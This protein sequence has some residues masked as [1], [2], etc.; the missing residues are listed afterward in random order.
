MGKVTAS[1]ISFL[2]LAAA[3][4]AQTTGTVTVGGRAVNDRGA[5][6]RAAEYLPTTSGTELALA[7]EAAL[8]TVYLAVDSD[9]REGSDQ[10]HHL[11]VELNRLVRSHTSFTKMPHRLV[12]DPLENL[13]GAVKMPVVT[14]S[15]DLDPTARYRVDYDLLENRTD[16]QLPQAGWLTVSAIYREQWRQG[17]R[18]SL[19]ISH[20]STCHVQS[21][22]RAVDE[23]TRDAGVVAQ[24]RAGSWKLEGSFVARDFEEKAPTPTRVYE[25]AEQ[26]ALRQPLFNDRVWYDSKNGPL[27]YGVIPPSEKNTATARLSNPNVGGFAVTLSGVSTRL[28]NLTTGNKVDFD[29]IALAVGRRLGKKG[30]FALRARSYTIDSTDYFVDVPEPKAVAGPYAGK[31]YYERYGFQPD[32]LRQSAIDR[33]V[34]EASARLSYRVG[35]GSSLIG[36]Y[37]FQN[38][39]RAHYEVAPGKTD[40]L[41]QRLKLAYSARPARGVN[42]RLEGILADVRRPFMTQNTACQTGP[43]QT[44]PL[45]SPIVP[46]SVQYYEIYRSRIGDMTA[47]PS[48]YVQLKGTA[49]LTLGPTTNASLS[50]LWWDGDNTDQDLTNWSRTTTAANAQVAWAPN[51]SFQ[52][53]VAAST[54]M[55]KLKSW[56]CVPL[57]DG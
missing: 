40:T 25:L 18:Q 56:V 11:R 16:L 38:I 32:F 51:E 33:D 1:F 52:A 46:G 13:R 17:H 12:H 41:T 43:L 6:E 49:A 42:F 35:R 45:P 34:T 48:S 9:A 24:V 14:W 7:L 29:A 36:E 57:M 22:T 53:F 4:A 5:P 27:P 54:G 3:A 23:R 2:L 10:V 8:D 31:S 28:E 20:C 26:P 39:D 15:T 55:R 21:Q 19:A 30:T 37:T 47:S 44:T 50:L